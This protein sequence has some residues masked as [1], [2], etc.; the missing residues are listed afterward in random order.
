MWSIQRSNE[1]ID[2]K[3]IEQKV[4]EMLIPENLKIEIQMNGKWEL[5]NEIQ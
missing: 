3:T 5:E 4:E 1:I 2:G